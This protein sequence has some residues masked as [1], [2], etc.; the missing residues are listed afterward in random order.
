MTFVSGV[1]EFTRLRVNQ[2]ASD[3]H[4]LFT[5]NPGNF[6]AQTSVAFSVV[7]PD[8]SVDRK[9]VTFTLI[10]DVTSLADVSSSLVTTSITAA[11]AMQLDID[12]SRIADFYYEIVSYCS[13]VNVQLMCMSPLLLM[14]MSRFQE[15]WW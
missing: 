7:A 13:H 8:D 6:Q 2:P 10:G 15:R 9:V 11:L 1:A 3:L 14:V 4:L 12:L 5:T